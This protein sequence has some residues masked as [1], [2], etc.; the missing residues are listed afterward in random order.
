[1][2]RLYYNTKTFLILFALLLV[3][4]SAHAVSGNKYVVTQVHDGDTISIKAESFAGFP[5]RIEKVRLIGID[6]PELKQEPWGRKAKKHLKKLLSESDWIVNVEFDVQERDKYGRLLGYIWSRNKG[7]LI[8]QKMI[9][10]GMA[11]LFTFP[12]NVRYEDRFTEAE[13]MASKK[14]IGL[15]GPNGLTQKPADWRREHPREDTEQH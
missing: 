3:A 12:P 10:D 11:V 1:M 9:E 6:T 15:W 5:L 7:I 13:K 4:S 8:N 2:Y 14:G